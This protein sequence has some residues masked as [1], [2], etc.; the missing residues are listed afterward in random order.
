MLSFIVTSLAS[1]NLNVEDDIY[2][3]I[4]IFNLTTRIF[5]KTD[6]KTNLT[7]QVWIQITFNLIWK[8]NFLKRKT[9]VQPH[10]SFFGFA[11]PDLSP[12]MK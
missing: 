12:C 9:A 3:A 7:I 11:R 8:L 4:S 6:K 10:A 5:Y 2:V 1:P